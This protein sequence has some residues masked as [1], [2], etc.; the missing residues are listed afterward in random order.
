M[1]S[2]LDEYLLEYELFLAEDEML[3]TLFQLEAGY[4]NESTG[5]ISLNESFAD[6]LKE[7][8]Q[9]IMNGITGAYDKLKGKLD[10]IYE[11]K[12]KNMS[13][14]FEDPNKVAPEGIEITNYHIY[15]Y[16]KLANYSAQT[17]LNS[18]DYKQTV[19]GLVGGQENKGNIPSKNDIIK[20]IYPDLYA[21][22]TSLF[23]QMR[24]NITKSGNDNNATTILTLE[25]LNDCWNF[26]FKTRHD[27]IVSIDK[28]KNLIKEQK[29]Q[30]DTI[31]TEL[32]NSINMSMQR[33]PQQQET[34]ES[35]L[36]ESYLIEDDNF[37]SQSIKDTPQEEKKDNKK[38]YSKILIS[39]IQV[40]T[41]MI[42]AKMKLTNTIFME[43]YKIVMHYAIK[44]KWTKLTKKDKDNN[45]KEEENNKE[46]NK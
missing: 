14:K 23:D 21:E 32:A 40:V 38:M 19:A 17:A 43:K 44:Q 3:Q 20:K 37:K 34:S 22:D 39:Y 26:C 7:W 33:N 25:M 9:K 18:S 27:L 30:I 6:T 1:D 28:D 16:D 36:I 41:N 29:K 31:A 10:N 35:F 45:K 4:L 8:F 46:E 15:D 11:D 13:N 5:L 2:L 42:S 24:K 12:L